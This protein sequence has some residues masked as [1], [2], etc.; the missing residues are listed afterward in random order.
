MPKIVL[1]IFSILVVLLILVFVASAVA[2]S[3]LERQVEKEVEELFGSSPE[4]KKEIITEADL[5][6][7]P[8]CVQKWLERTQ[9]V[10]KEKIRTVRLKQKGL[11]RLT[12]DQPWMPFEAE[13]YF[14]VDQPGFVWKAKVKMNPLLYFTGRDRYF[15]G[16]G[17]MNIKVLS[18]L[19]VVN[20]GGSSEMDQN[21]LL[22]YLAEIAWFPTAAL[23]DYIKWEDIDANSARATMS[24]NGV[25]SSG[26]YTFDDNGDV[27][28]FFAKRYWEVNGQY[29][30]NPW[31]GVV[32]GY[33]EF[34]GFRISSKTDVIWKLETG[35]FHWLQVEITDIDYNKPQL[36]Q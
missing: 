17:E 6:G 28:S 21:T 19:P 15:Q 36:Y 7:L 35:D 12:E 30:L 4:D 16:H 31:G 18:I 11:L 5:A 3:L 22:R 14:N 20:A 34:N 13:Q 2:N 26:V 29:V 33:N 9:V 27:V 1:I 10:G 25:T 32:K 23:N 24:Y 8:P